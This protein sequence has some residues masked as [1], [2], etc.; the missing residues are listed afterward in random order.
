ML[1]RRL[2]DEQGIALVTTIVLTAV[3]LVL[4]AAILGLVITQTGETK[5]ER[6]GESAFNLAEATLNA[7]AFLLGRSWPQTPVAGTCKANEITGDLTAPA[8]TTLLKD[9]VQSILQQTYDGSSNATSSKWWVTACADG[10]R[11]S[12]DASLL[13]GLSYDT[14]PTTAGPRRMWVRAEAEINGHNRAVVGLVQAAHQPVFP[15]NLAVV[16]GKIGTDLGTSLN[17]ITN[18]TLLNSIKSLLIQ[19]DPM[20]VGNVGLRCSLLDGGTPPLTGCI[21]GV[22]KATS[23]TSLGPLLSANNYAHFSSDSTISSEQVALL[24][25]Q[26][27]ATGTYL[28]NTSSAVGGVADG[29]SCLPAGSAGK[30]VFIEQ[31]GDGTGSC[32]INA[33]GGASAAAV[34][35]GSGGVRVTS[36]PTAGGTYTGV[37][38]ALHRKTLAGNA[39]DVR[40]ENGAHVVG[41]VFV[42]DNAD[43]PAASQRGSV[44]VIPPP[45]NMATLINSLAVCAPVTVLLVTT[46]PCAAVV[47]LAGTNLDDALTLLTT[48]TGAAGLSQLTTAITAQLDSSFPAITYSKATVD[49]ITTFGD[50]GVVTGT[51]RQVQPAH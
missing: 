32:I 40:I 46:Y 49:T 19:N 6:S 15:S 43:L 26:A 50:S 45:L 25:Q 28:A 44:Q 11:D 17:S 33:S 30:I 10:G 7:D 22:L 14:A 38:Y 51:F 42:D 3:M 12:W 47:A 16:T 29:A 34:I 21:T 27:K 35:V 2:Q 48:L 41:G 18:G 36:T 31:V 1:A 23:M 20:I 9:Q 5:V 13:N 8:T 4:G 39:A 24:R 37:I